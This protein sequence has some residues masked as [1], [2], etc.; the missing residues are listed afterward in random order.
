MEGAPASVPGGGPQDRRRAKRAAASS[1]W[2]AHRITDPEHKP[3]A[4]ITIQGS[5]RALRAPAALRA[6][7]RHGVT[8]CGVARRAQA[9]GASPWARGTP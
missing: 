1:P 5:Y 9:K 8:M 7:T 4:L 3:L 2:S 6:A